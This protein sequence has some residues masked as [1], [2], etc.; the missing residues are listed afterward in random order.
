MAISRVWQAGAELAGTG[1]F[2][3][4]TRDNTT[5]NIAS[6]TVARTGTYSFRGTSSTGW[7][8]SLASTLS[9]WRISL[10]LYHQGAGGGVYRSIASFST[11]STGV[12]SVRWNGTSGNLEIAKNADVNGSSAGTL[13]ASALIGDI[14]SIN[15]WM[16]IGI[17]AKLATTTGWVYVYLNGTLFLSFDG[18]TN[19]N[20]NTIGAVKLLSGSGNGW[21]NY[22]YIDDIYLDN[23]D[24]ESAP[25]PAPD[26]RFPYIV[27]NGAGN[28]TLWTPS[29]GNNFDR[30]KEIPPDGDTSYVQATSAGI[31]DSYD[32][33]SM[34]ALPTGWTIKAVIPVA[35][36][37]KTD[38]AVDS[39]VSL[40]TRLSSDEVIESGQAL[41]TDYASRWNRQ[42]AKPG[43]GQWEEADVNDAQ[44]IIESAGTF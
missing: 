5:N 36:A 38:G 21:A 24:G 12:I 26:L 33:T 3:F 27:P 4:T 1:L 2:E 44:V 28:S 18:T 22:N 13:L 8:L 35:V 14:A 9:Q 32:L 19:I 31:K 11:G 42:T 25:A 30:V 16:H 29:S 39:Q 10:H 6:N 20:G 43:G 17:D 34:P 7:G 23:T 37:R 41:G 40:G 15:T